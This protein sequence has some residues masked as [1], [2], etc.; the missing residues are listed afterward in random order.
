MTARLL[1]ESWFEATL[2]TAVLAPL[3]LVVTGR[4]PRKGASPSSLT[5]AK[6]ISG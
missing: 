4:W 6:A 2:A 3:A 1:L 5:A